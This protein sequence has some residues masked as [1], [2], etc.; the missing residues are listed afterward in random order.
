MKSRSIVA[1][2]MLLAIVPIMAMAQ[3]PRAARASP[4]VAP[5]ALER[6][7]ASVSSQPDDIL[8]DYESEMI[9][10]T[11]GLDTDLAGILQAARANQI[12]REKAEYLIQ[13]RYQVAIM[14]HQVLSALH[15][16][17]EHDMAEAAAAKRSAAGSQSDQAVVVQLPPSEADSN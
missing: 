1:A 14:Q 13:E 10:I 3:K 4:A 12:T 7:L 16:R 8:K 5:P 9:M 15:D 2:L 6:V 17:M 11:Q